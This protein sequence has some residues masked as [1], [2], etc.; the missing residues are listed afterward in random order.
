M[1]PNRQSFCCDNLW[2]SILVA[3]EKPEKLGDF[4][5]YFVATLSAFTLLYQYAE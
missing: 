2:K 1:L 4:F 5:P 3:L